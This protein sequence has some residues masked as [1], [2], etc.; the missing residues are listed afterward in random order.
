MVAATPAVKGWRR[1]YVPEQKPNR[2]PWLGG[3]F[4]PT[5]SN[6]LNPISS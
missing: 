5:T 1:Y 2:L 6:H 4:E 3:G